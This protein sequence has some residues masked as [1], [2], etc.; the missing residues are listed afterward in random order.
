MPI[1][2][3]EEL[4]KHFVD[5]LLPV[6][7]YLFGSYASNTYTAESDFD[8]YIVVKDGVADLAAETTKAYKAVR[9]VK[10][11]PVD[12]LVGTKSRFE[13]RKDIPSI[14]NEVYKKGVLLYDVDNK[15]MV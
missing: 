6:Q 13:E 1:Q 11:R 4:K 7:I 10:K 2:E 8:F 9:R 3:I 12:I 15:R 14:E 5:Q